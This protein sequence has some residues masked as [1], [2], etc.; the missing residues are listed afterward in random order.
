MW[1]EKWIC[2][3]N[4]DVRSITQ[5]VRIQGWAGPSE[6][7]GMLLLST[8]I[9]QAKREV[10]G[11]LSSQGGSDGPGGLA[12]SR[13]GSYCQRNAQTWQEM[14]LVGVRKIGT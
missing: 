3:E 14:G 5:E 1:E 10:L 6:A 11:K 4:I 8:A 2:E 13:A 9:L 7:F 12:R